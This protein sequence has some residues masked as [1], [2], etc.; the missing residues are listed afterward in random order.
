[1]NCKTS[2]Q[3]LSGNSCLPKIPINWAIAFLTNFSCS[4][5]NAWSIPCLI[6]FLVSASNLLH[7]RF[8]PSFRLSNTAA[9]CLICE[10]CDETITSQRAGIASGFLKASFSSL[11]PYRLF[12]NKYTCLV[13]LRM[14]LWHIDCDFKFTCWMTLL[15]ATSSFD[16]ISSI[17]NLF[18]NWHT[19]KR[20]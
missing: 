7:C 16:K 1:M 14:G 10:F 5:T 18:T 17:L 9:D 12:G 13:R 2:G 3:V 8:L 6:L 19:I 15:L 4:L 20:N 11:V